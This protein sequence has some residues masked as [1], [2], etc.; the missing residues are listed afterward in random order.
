MFSEKRAGRR[1]SWY[2]FGIPQADN[3]LAQVSNRG[4]IVVSLLIGK[5]LQPV[6]PAKQIF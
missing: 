4:F 5:K 2:T 6:V 1:M 3:S